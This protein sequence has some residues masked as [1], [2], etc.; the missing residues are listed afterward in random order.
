MF[1]HGNNCHTKPAVKPA[2]QG[3]FGQ[4]N[5]IEKVKRKKLIMCWDANDVFEYEFYSENN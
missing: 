5:I 3:G 4:K 1:I 2:V